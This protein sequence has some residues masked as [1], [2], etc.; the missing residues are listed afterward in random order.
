MAQS[1]NTDKS[2]PPVFSSML[3]KMDINPEAVTKGFKDVGDSPEKLRALLNMWLTPWF[4]PTFA[5]DADYGYAGPHDVDFLGFAELPQGQLPYRM[6]DVETG[7]LVEFPAIGPRG[8][9]CMLS[10]RWKGVE[11]ALGYVNEARRKG[12][13]RSREARQKND[14]EL[15]LEQCRSDLEE[16]E[17]L[18]KALCSGVDGQVDIGDLLSRRFDART[19]EEAVGQAR[20]R[21]YQIRSQIRFAQMEQK[22]FGD[23]VK[24][25]ENPPTSQQSKIDEVVK[26]GKDVLDGLHRELYEVKTTIRTVE[27]TRNSLRTHFQEH[28]DLRDALDELICRLQRWKS[29]IKLQRA[30]QQAGDI[31]KNKHFQTRE[32]CYLW[33]D[34]C[35]IDKANAGELSESLSLMGDWYATAEFTLVQIDTPFREADAVE[36]WHRFEET[37][38]TREDETAGVTPNIPSF[39]DIKDYGPEWSTRAW[40]LQE[41]VMSKMTFYANSAW[42]PLSRPVESLGYLYHLVPFLALYTR[43]NPRN[44]YGSSLASVRGF[45]DVNILADILADQPALDRLDQL[46]KDIKG[47]QA[48]LGDELPPDAASRVEVAQHLIA[49]LGALDFQIPDTLTSETAIIEIGQAV[50]LALSDIESDLPDTDTCRRDA[51][52]SLF[53]RLEEQL[54][55][56]NLK[57]LPPGF[58]K[59]DMELQKMHHAIQFLLQ[60][61]VAEAEDLILAD[62]QYVAEFGQVQQ[63]ET[64][65]LGTCRSGFPAHHVLEASVKRKATVATD[66][67]YALMGIL[68]VRFPTFPAEGYSKALARLLDE[69][70]ITRNDVS[71]FNWTGMEMG[72]PIRGRSMYPRSQAAYGH[73][74]DLGR[75]YNLVLSAGVRENVQDILHTYESVIDTLKDAIKLL[76]DKERKSLPL[77]WVKRIVAIVVERNFQELKSL[78]EGLGKIIGYVGQCRKEEKEPV[79]KMAAAKAESAE[80]PT[81]TRKGFFKRPTLPSALSMPSPSTSS[82][83]LSGFKNPAPVKNEAESTETTKKGSRFSFG[84]GMKSSSFSLSRKVT[85]L[86]EE[87]E[88]LVAEEVPVVLPNPEEAEPTPDPPP[89]CEGE[90]PSALPSWTTMNEPVMKYLEAKYLE[91]KYLDEDPCTLPPDIESVKFD[92]GDDEQTAFSNITGW[93]D[94]H[95]AQDLDT[96]SPN[97]IVVNNSGI[98]GLFDIQRVIVTM[99]EPD[100][101]RKQVGRAAS[102]HARITGWCSISTGFANVVTS[103]TCERRL[104]EQELG[105]IE[106]VET[107]VLQEQ[108]KDKS[109]KRGTRILKDSVVSGSASNKPAEKEAGQSADPQA[110][111]G[112]SQKGEAKDASESVDDGVAEPTDPPTGE[113]NDGSAAQGTGDYQQAPGEDKDNDNDKD[114][115]AKSDNTEEERRVSRMIDFIQEPQL[116]LIAGEWVLARFSAC[117]GA[118]WFLCHLEL[119]PTH[120]QFYGYRIAAGAID[121]S[122]PTPEPGLVGV[123]KT[124]MDRKK[125][126]MCRILSEYVESREACSEVE[127]LMMGPEF[128]RKGFDSFEMPTM[129][130]VFSSG[131]DKPPAEVVVDEGS[132]SEG[133]WEGE[134]KGKWEGEGEGEG[135]ESNDKSEKGEDDNSLDVVA[136]LNQMLKTGKLA[137]KTFGHLASSAVQEKYHELHAAYLDKKLTKA[138]LK[139]TPKSLRSAVENMQDNKSFLPAMFH[140]ST[141]VAMF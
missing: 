31:F 84:K 113:K 89:A 4:K 47:N 86:S 78:R 38:R 130:E 75:R 59:G 126:R 87:T 83:S 104:L 98:E 35:C 100:K 141:R 120:G 119:G 20:D 118:N 44:M 127:K 41:L 30:I 2:R 131:A 65:Q 37:S 67:S 114:K 74:Q 36:D 28:R 39:K 111:E 122:K 132:K 17:V 48:G 55:T 135:E 19:A 115:E 82:F 124:Y 32:N 1:L 125:R 9:Y 33:T 68:G 3:K 14:V 5:P 60:C 56:P 42:T 34:T 43:A 8:Q 134:G 96:I 91:A 136:L 138:V 107:W 52:R 45:R 77:E 70:V 99:I 110:G 21:E 72:S 64:W 121:F 63:L 50:Y 90:P 22:V 40:T 66:R 57:C 23:L 128:L 85:A 53:L 106:S 6:F 133:E 105:V 95:P 108:T 101:L 73:S 61:L 102:P 51:K 139:Q 69:V 27:V 26:L 129:K 18:V 16:Q 88:P 137:A 10:H 46:R 94:S 62:R 97:P 109:E 25:M 71:V 80:S 7:N 112:K 140:S 117:P 15:V 54:P 49:L 11:L 92:V 24:D 93:K 103:F 81:D 76:K 29:A 79:A 58:E 12:R 116:E 13:E 123:W